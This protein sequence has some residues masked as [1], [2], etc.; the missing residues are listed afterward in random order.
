MKRHI[1]RFWMK[2]ISCGEIMPQDRPLHTCIKC[3]GLLMPERDEDYIRRKIGY[4]KDA[5]SHF[6]MLLNKNHIYPNDS[7]VFRYRHYL[8]P[9]FPEKA[10]IASREGRT[11]LLT[12]PEWLLKKLG[13]RTFY[14][15]MEGLNPTGSFKDR[16]ACVGLSEAY[17]LIL[18]FPELGI[19]GVA[20]AST[21]D[22]SAAVAYYARQKGIKCVVLLPHDKI[23]DG[24]LA[25]AMMS[26]AIVLAI[27][28]DN[29]FDDCMKL[30]TEFSKAHPEFILMNSK[31]PFR[32]IGQ[33]AIALEIFEGLGWRAPEWISIPV[34]NGGNLTSLMM[35]CLRAK[36]LGLIDRLPGIIVGQ[37]KTTNTLVRWARSGF[38]DYKPGNFVESVASAMNIQKPVSFERIKSLYKEFDRLEFFDVSEEEIQDTRALFDSVCPQGAV[39]VHALMQAQNRGLIKGR[40]PIVA[41][42]TATNLKFTPTAIDYHLGSGKYA[43]PYKIVNA[44]M[45]DIDKAIII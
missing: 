9:G 39:A 38:K 12:P 31:N 22:T 3:D 32:L 2:C 1:L 37:I 28:S 33:E 43:N 20:C 30:I 14:I 25:Q 23:S 5:Q 11:D 15:K 35:S 34:G 44:D 13:L 29:G 18:Y 19:Q 6:R 21:G 4:G 24:Q 7:G 40:G 16:G 26:G 45:K 8:I 42:S 27:R 10:I 41:I 17:R 36:R